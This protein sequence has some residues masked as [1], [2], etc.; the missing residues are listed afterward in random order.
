MFNK[1]CTTFD[2]AVE[3][4]LAA[5]S[6]LDSQLR[7]ATL[8]HVSEVETEEGIRYFAGAESPRVV[9]S[10]WWVKKRDEGWQVEPA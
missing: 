3:E 4:A 1:L 5:H 9:T 6:K 10:G 7:S 8:P 2:E